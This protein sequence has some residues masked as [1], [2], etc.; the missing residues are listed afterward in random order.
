MVVE[1]WRP[2]QVRGI[3]QDKY[4]ISNTGPVRNTSTGNMMSECLSEKGYVMVGLM[5]EDGNQ[6]TL[7]LHRLVAETFIPPVPGKNEIDHIDG[8]KTHNGIDNLEWVDRLENIRRA[9]AKGL[10]PHK[11]G[12]EVYNSKFTE[13]QIREIGSMMEKKM[14]PRDIM[15]ICNERGI[16]LKRCNYDDMKRRRNYTDILKAYNF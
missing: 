5:C 9:E 15:R 13:E 2:L 1:E 6:H 8:D 14:K 16:P 10:V 12:T 11:K 4:L 7:K 3:K